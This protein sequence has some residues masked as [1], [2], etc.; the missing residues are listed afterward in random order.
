[1]HRTLGYFVPLQVVLT[2]W[3]SQ[4]RTYNV[5]HLGVLNALVPLQ[6][7]ASGHGSIHASDNQVHIPG[8][9]DNVY[10]SSQTLLCHWI[11]FSEAGLGANDV[12]GN[13]GRS[14]PNRSHRPKPERRPTEICSAK[15]NL[16]YVSEDTR[17]GLCVRI[18]WRQVCHKGS[19][20]SWQI[21]GRV[22]IRFC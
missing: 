13:C 14:H 15:S 7:F 3:A 8:V 1:M 19:P 11:T 18:L 2:S 12:R 9:Q 6:V 20:D 16:G 10:H 5:A 17:S 22:K 21:W 4:K